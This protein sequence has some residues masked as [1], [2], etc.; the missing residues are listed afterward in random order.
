MSCI[1][2][3]YRWTVHLASHSC[4]KAVFPALPPRRIAPRALIR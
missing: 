2:L 4:D 3:P 1:A